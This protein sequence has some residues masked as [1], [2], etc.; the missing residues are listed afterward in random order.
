[1]EAGE[2]P[3]AIRGQKWSGVD[4]MI[5]TTLDERTA[6]QRV[7]QGHLHRQGWKAKTSTSPHRVQGIP[8]AQPS[9]SGKDVVRIAYRRRCGL[10]RTT[11]AT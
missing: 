7:Y 11:A 6:Q 4:V 3:T 5:N 9:T 2:V 10:Q 1:M 8:S